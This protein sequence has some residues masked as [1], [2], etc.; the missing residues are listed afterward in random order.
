M[1]AI[2]ANYPLALIMAAAILAFA[3]VLVFTGGPVRAA[4]MDHR[5]ESWFKETFIYRTYL[6][7]EHITI[8]SEYGVVILSGAVADETHK[9]MAQSVTESLPGVISVDNRLEITGDRPA[10]NSDARLSMKVKAALLFHRSVSGIKTEVYV[11][12][13]IVT[14][15]GDASSQVQKELTTEFAKDVEGVKGMNNE[16]TVAT[17]TMQTDETM[18]EKIDDASITAQVKMTLASHRSTMGL[19]TKVTTRDGIVTLRG[20]ARNETEKVLVTNLIADIDGV[21]RVF[22]I[23]TIE[24]VVSSNN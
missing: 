17:T 9:S 23:M 8:S 18:S 5:I 11:K 10:E 3:A 4:E 7:D 15:K 21:R 19:N 14:L 6:K 13:G 2:K 12:D 16:M 20:Q 1:K 24:T 22:N